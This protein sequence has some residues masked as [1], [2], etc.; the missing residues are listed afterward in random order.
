MT[1]LLTQ[2]GKGDPKGDAT[3]WSFPRQP[4]RGSLNASLSRI[5]ALGECIRL[6]QLL[7]LQFNL[8]VSYPV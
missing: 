3:V 8:P 2:K 4:R 7:C 6:K 5:G 1:P